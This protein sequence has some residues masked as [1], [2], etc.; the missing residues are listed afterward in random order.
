MMRMRNLVNGL[1]VTGVAL[2][3]VSS[4]AA[5]TV[6][7]TSAK[8]VRVKGSARYKTDSNAWQPLTHGTV[9]KAGA[10]V[11][12]AGEGSYVD[13]VLGE[14]ARPQLRPAAADMLTYHPVA[15]QNTVRIWENSRLG[16]DKL[17]STETGADVV[18][19]THL[20]LQAGHIFGSVRKMSAA[21]KYEVKIP[22]GVASIR[23]TVYDISAEG[24]IKVLVG[25]VLLDY[26]DA[27]GKQLKQPIMALEEFDA[28]TGV[29]KALP[30]VDREGMVK[31]LSLVWMFAPGAQLPPG[32]NLVTVTRPTPTIPIVTPTPPPVS[33]F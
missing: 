10:L 23:G 1:V 4:L 17:T 19:E 7:Q 25:S 30:D 26:T 31:A 3:M 22:N 11:E 12:T 21:S 9:L 32:L 24:V 18:T 16:L 6:V 5:Q 13:L 20:D 28:R 14:G 27:N 29:L 2:A 33:P 15:E 8:V